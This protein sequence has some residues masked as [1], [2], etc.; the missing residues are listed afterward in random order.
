MDQADLKEPAERVAS[1]EVSPDELV[2]RLRVDSVSDLGYAKVDNQRGVR[3]GAGEVVYG[4][5]KTAE[6][7]AGILK[8]MHAAGQERT[9]VTRLS[10]DK[11]ARM[12]GLLPD[13]V[14]ARFSYRELPAASSS[15]LRARATCP[16]RRRP[17]SRRSFSATR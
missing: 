4:A 7:I 2:R 3:T 1:G 17:P 10:P 9:L 13:E 14:S 6:Q 15:R 5:G 8:A 11:C 12:L 16:L